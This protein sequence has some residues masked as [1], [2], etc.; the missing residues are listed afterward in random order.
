MPE[1]LAYVPPRLEAAAPARLVVC[2]HGISRD[3]REQI[4]L[5]REEAEQRGYALLAPRFSERAWPD[6]QRLGRRG[7]GPRA[8]LGVDLAIERLEHQ[9]GLRFGDRF[10]LGYSGGAQFVHRYAM[11]HPDRV[12]AAVCA[13]AGW[14]T[15]PETQRR[16]PYGLRVEGSLAGVRLEPEAFLRVPLLVAVGRKDTTREAMRS[17]PRLDAEQGRHRLERA[18]RWTDAMRRA[19]ER[20][21]LESSVE[22]ALIEGAGHA[23]SECVRG[24]LARLAFDFFDNRKG[25]P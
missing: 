11:A 6:Y 2:V 20:R 15:L 4:E 7:R 16:Y 9:L 21:G 3:H 17:R 1:C 24:G 5:L 10:L 22:L 13:A 25:N 8:D 23:F 18:E 12:R 19:A 14:Y